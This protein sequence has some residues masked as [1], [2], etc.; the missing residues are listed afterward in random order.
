MRTCKRKPNTFYFNK[1]IKVNIPRC[2]NRNSDN[3][4]TTIHLQSG[5][6]PLS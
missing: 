4:M 1:I 2:C 5:T 3:L 6:L